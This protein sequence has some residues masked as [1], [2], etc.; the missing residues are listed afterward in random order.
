MTSEKNIGYLHFLLGLVALVAGIVNAMS[1]VFYPCALTL[2]PASGL[3]FLGAVQRKELWG[4]WT[5]QVLLGVVG[6]AI[7]Y[8]GIWELL[9]LTSWNDLLHFFMLLTGLYFCYFLK[10]SKVTLK[11]SI[12]LGVTFIAFLRVAYLNGLF[13][14]SLQ[15]KIPVLREIGACFISLM[16]TGSIWLGILCWKYGSPKKHE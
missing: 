2:I 6:L 12:P 5:P 14:L 7:T 3:Y 11:F 8:A 1:N 10:P 4:R 16:L 15:L 13:D 9:I